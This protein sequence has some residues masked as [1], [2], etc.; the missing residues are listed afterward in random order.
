MCSL[1]NQRGHNPLSLMLLNMETDPTGKNDSTQ[2]IIAAA[3]AAKNG[4]TVYF[5]AGT[6][7]YNQS[8]TTI[9]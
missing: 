3:T 8:V 2:A 6:F 1:D 5:P 7:L 9:A 4:G